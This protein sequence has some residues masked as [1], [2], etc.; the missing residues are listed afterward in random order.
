MRLHRRRAWFET[1]SGFAAALLTMPEA[2]D[3]I[4]KD[5]ILRSRAKRG[6]EGRT[7][8]IQPPAERYTGA[9][10]APFH[11]KRRAANRGTAIKCGGHGH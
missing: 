2:Y 7:A 3:G 1:G 6:L 11:D 8:L 5:V 9:P 10:S 4:K